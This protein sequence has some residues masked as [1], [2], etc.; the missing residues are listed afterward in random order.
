MNQSNQRIAK[1]TL[2]LYIRFAIVLVANLYITRAVL[3]VLGA[4]DYGLYN[5]VCGFVAMFGFLNTS[6]TNG[7]QRFYNYELGKNGDKSV[8]KVF[9]T[10]IFIQLI[11][12]AIVL[13]FAETVGLWYINF[14][15]V[16]PDARMLAANWAFQFSVISLLFVIIQIPYSAAILAYERMDYYAII[17][18]V[19]IGLKL[20]AVIILPYVV[21]DHLIVYGASIMGITILSFVLNYLYCHKH[22]SA[23]R[24]NR[25]FDREQFK[26]MI[27]FSGWHLLSTIAYLAKGQGVPVLINM[28]FGTIVNAANGIAA[29]ISSAIQTFSANLIVAFKPQLTQSYAIGDYHRTEQLMFTM[30]KISYVLM[31]ILAIP[32]ITDIDYILHVWLG[33]DVPEYTSTF[34]IL[35]IIAMMIGVFNTPITQVVHSTGRIKLY[36]IMTS[37]VIF[38]VLPIS[39]IFLKLGYSVD[40]VFVITI[41]VVLVNQ[42]VSLFVLKQIFNYDLGKYIRNVIAPCLLMTAVAMIIAVGIRDLMSASFLR[43]ITIFVVSLFV[44]V[45]VVGL[46]L[47]RAEKNEARSICRKLL[48]RK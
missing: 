30:S 6:M 31:C 8:A 27:S 23:F 37:I 43:F 24:F 42:I 2:F 22:F 7:I 46:T 9:N 16:I 4:S 47:N 39:W 41:V 34:S 25:Q 12:A 10:A 3:N 26:S 48:H 45:L 44:I 33:G 13:V 19:E 38:S 18:I 32:I 36:E 14:Q 15:M 5:V 17:S 40:S 35:T 21:G 11:L 28:F 1:N 29:Q 20:V